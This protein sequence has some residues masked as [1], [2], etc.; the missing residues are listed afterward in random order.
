M[1]ACLILFFISNQ[2]MNK[3]AQG[4]PASIPEGFQIHV[5]QYF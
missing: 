2:T 5:L 1:K 3:A 4:K